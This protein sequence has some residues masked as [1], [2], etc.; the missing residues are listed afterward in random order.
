MRTL[1]RPPHADPPHLTIYSA[2]DHGVLPWPRSESL[3]VSPIACFETRRHNGSCVSAICKHSDVLTP[4]PRF[5]FTNLKWQ[6]GRK[7]F[8][9][10]DLKHTEFSKPE[11][12]EVAVAYTDGLQWASARLVVPVHFIL[13]GALRCLK[14]ATS[15][16]PPP[17]PPPPDPGLLLVPGTTQYSRQGA[18]LI[19]GRHTRPQKNSESSIEGGPS[20]RASY[21]TT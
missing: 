11:R 4:G 17:H 21:A 15:R 12:L 16:S 20:G 10:T 1:I 2:C 13:Q 19:E 9:F 8:I 6:G 3:I 14:R 18:P 7:L 5:L